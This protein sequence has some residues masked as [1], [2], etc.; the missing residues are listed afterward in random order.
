MKKAL[1]ASLVSAG[2][3]AS[4]SAQTVAMDWTRTDCNGNT[5]TL[6]SELDSGYCIILEFVMVP[7]CTPCYTAA[8]HLADIRDQLEAAYPGRVR[9]YSIAYNNTY[10]CSNMQTWESNHGLTPDAMFIQGS[11][12]VS[13]YGG[14]G[15]PTIA[16]VGTANHSVFYK[17]QG[18]NTNDTAN[19]RSA[20]VQALSGGS[21]G[22]TELSA[23]DFSISIAPNPA[24]DNLTIALTAPNSGQVTVELMSVTGSKVSH[25][26]AG[27]VS[28]TKA[29]GL[30]L[31]GLAP[32][33]YLLVA[34]TEDASRTMILSVNR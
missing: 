12:E 16:V 13:Y 11:T 21:T 33:L 26:Y 30:S 32:G 19:I 20:L 14:M 22:T 7:S 27:P 6:F 24:S 1:L 28:G 2:M 31:E 10:T 8:G 3:L 9:L 29:I 17:K 18:F 23:A 25:V 15:M 34:R 5:H 4:A